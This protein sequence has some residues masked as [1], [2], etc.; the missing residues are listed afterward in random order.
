MTKSKPRVKV[1]DLE[2]IIIKIGPRYCKFKSLEQKIPTGLSVL[3]PQFRNFML[4]IPT[5][6]W[7]NKDGEPFTVWADTVA[8]HGVIVL[9]AEVNLSVT[10]QSEGGRYG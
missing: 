1:I 8:S 7:C 6:V 10:N 3:F 4:W 9:G 5:M 2:E